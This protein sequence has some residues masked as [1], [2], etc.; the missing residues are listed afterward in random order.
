MNASA[1][2][3]VWRRHDVV[4]AIF[5]FCSINDVSACAQVSKFVHT[6]AIK[7][8]YRDIN[9]LEDILHLLAPMSGSKERWFIH[10]LMPSNW[11]KFIP[12]A[13]LVRHIRYDET[14]SSCYAP[15]DDD[16]FNEIAVTCPE[17]PIFPVLESAHFSWNT[18]EGSS[19]ARYSLMFLNKKLKT[20][21]LASDY[22]LEY[23]L[24]SIPRASPRLEWVKVRCPGVSDSETRSELVAMIDGLSHLQSLTLSTPLFSTE[25]ISSLSRHSKLVSL[26][27]DSETTQEQGDDCTRDLKLS[28][29][30]FKSLRDLRLEIHLDAI[31]RWFP[32]ANVMPS[33]VTLH[34][35]L[36]AA[37]AQS[38]IKDCFALLAKAIPHVVELKFD[39][40]K[41]ASSTANRVC[42]ISL[43]T[44]EPLL[45]RMAPSTFFFDHPAPLPLTDSD[46]EKLAI[47]WPS[48]KNL[49]LGHS[50]AAGD[51]RCVLTLNVLSALAR[52]CPNLQT[53]HLNINLCFSP[54][55]HR[56]PA[57]V[58]DDVPFSRSFVRLNLGYSLIQ[59]TQ[60]LAWF[61]SCILPE[62][63]EL[64]RWPEIIEKSNRDAKPQWFSDARERRWIDLVSWFEAYSKSRNRQDSRMKRA[65]D[66]ALSE[67]NEVKRENAKLRLKIDRLRKAN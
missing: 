18:H 20:L 6:R 50:S 46:V 51:T 10:P 40:Y 57:E 31:A 17:R 2:E 16:S 3:T 30:A 1:R 38:G 59:D 45:S 64:N 5:K 54:Y 8:L 55:R 41:H 49:S 13:Q 58:P 25:L 66:A 22:G 43:N 9:G 39:L 44:F 47:A 34:L 65:L 27:Q 24:R 48:L 53:L 60:S 61:L 32:S 23:V 62:S 21:S 11:E 19:R 33:L 42:D 12:Y 28:D 14:P 4:D 26:C 67:L 29:S 36:R 35:E 63:S 37:E 15:I 52:H 7:Y 56:L